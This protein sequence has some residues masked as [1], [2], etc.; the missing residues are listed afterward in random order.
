[1]GRKNHNPHPR[2]L[3]LTDRYDLDYV[4]LPEYPQYVQII[5]KQHK[6]IYKNMDADFDAFN[7]YV[8]HRSND[9]ILRLLESRIGFEV[10]G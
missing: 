6:T 1:M 7:E 4:N 5:V 3:R 9:P 8:V 2:K 10:I